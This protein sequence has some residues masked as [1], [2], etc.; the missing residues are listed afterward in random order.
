[1]ESD[2]PLITELG[3]ATLSDKASYGRQDLEELR[4]IFVRNGIPSE[5]LSHY[6]PDSPFAYLKLNNGL[7]DKF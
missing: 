2:T 3:V 6:V 5:F 1:M 4:K 7:S